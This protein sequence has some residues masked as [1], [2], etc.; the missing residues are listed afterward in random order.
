[1]PDDLQIVSVKLPKAQIDQIEKVRL[2]EHART[3][4]I[5]TRSEVIR[6]HLTRSLTA[7]LTAS[8]VTDISMDAELKDIPVSESSDREDDEA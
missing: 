4:R 1:M 2:A 7:S 5:P 8:G 3:G 6:D